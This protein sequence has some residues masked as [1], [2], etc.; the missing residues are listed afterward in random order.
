MLYLNVFKPH[1]LQ[2][3]SQRLTL[4]SVVFELMRE[5]KF[6][7]KFARLTLTSVVFELFV[8]FLLLNFSTWLTLTSVVFESW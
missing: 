8:L 2:F 3:L 1:D 7:G 6:R 4:T 5:I